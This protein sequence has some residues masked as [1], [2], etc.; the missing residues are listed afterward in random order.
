MNIRF[1]VMRDL[2]YI[3]SLLKTVLNDWTIMTD[4]N[5]EKETENF[6]TGQ[7]DFCKLLII[8]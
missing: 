2:P 3:M 6:Y 8:Y 5:M 7:L 4:D 1:A